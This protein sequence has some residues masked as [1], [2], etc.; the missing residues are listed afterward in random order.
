MS[1]TDTSS[2]CKL[3]ISEEAVSKKAITLERYWDEVKKISKSV[4]LSQF[5]TIDQ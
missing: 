3:D 5:L 2:W 1:E 4:R